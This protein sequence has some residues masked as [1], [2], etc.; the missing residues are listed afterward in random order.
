M[1]P[2]LVTKTTLDTNL[3][4]SFP[5]TP[6]LE[7]KDA[8]WKTIRIINSLKADIINFN[9]DPQIE[10]RLKNQVCVWHYYKTTISGQ[11]FTKYKCL[12]CDKEDYWHNTNT[13]KLC[14]PCAQKYDL[15]VK[16]GADIN[17]DP[18]KDIIF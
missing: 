3:N 14:L 8:T 16:C 10:D 7:V 4:N 2:I 1:N 9:S 12:I 11:G 13:P 6:K 15:C 17:L 18:E 5:G